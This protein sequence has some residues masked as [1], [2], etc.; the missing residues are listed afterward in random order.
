M[1]AAER[2]R[3]ALQLQPYYVAARAGLGVTLASI[4]EECRIVRPAHS[5]PLLG[6]EWVKELTTPKAWSLRSSHDSTKKG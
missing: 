5:L 6:M 1:E 2:F 3:Q 4:V